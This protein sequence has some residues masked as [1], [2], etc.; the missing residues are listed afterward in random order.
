[1]MLKYLHLPFALSVPIF[2]LC[3]V[4]PKKRPLR[5]SPP[6][7]SLGAGCKAFK[8]ITLKDKHLERKN[9][10]HI[11]LIRGFSGTDLLISLLLLEAVGVFGCFI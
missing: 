9:S 1:M 3:R 7:H 6:F 10:T 5:F 11:Y 4:C 8:K 2:I